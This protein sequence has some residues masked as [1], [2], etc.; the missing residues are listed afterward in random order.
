M[1]ALRD[2]LKDA[3]SAFEHKYDYRYSQLIIVFGHLTREGRIQEEDLEGLS[4]D[5]LERIR[6]IAAFV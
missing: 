1:W 4:P 3:Q 2:Y 5:K 6:R